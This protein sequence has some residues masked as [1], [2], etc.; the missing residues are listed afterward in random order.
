M[1]G[2]L[3][4]HIGDFMHCGEDSFSEK[5]TDKLRQKFV[6]RKME[7]REFKYVGFGIMQNPDEVILDQG[8][9]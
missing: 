4:T 9:Y 1:I 6:V 7:E 8:Q 2:A 3:V 5:V